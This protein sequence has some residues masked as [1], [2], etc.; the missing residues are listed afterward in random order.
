KRFTKN[1]R[2][3]SRGTLPL[4]ENPAITTPHFV[5][6]R[7]LLASDKSDAELGSCIAKRKA[8]RASSRA[9]KDRQSGSNSG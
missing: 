2:S 3:I 8:N 1:L 4:L 6:T 9:K 5:P 7:A